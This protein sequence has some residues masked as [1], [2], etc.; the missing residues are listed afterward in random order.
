MTT[1]PIFEVVGDGRVRL[2]PRE[3]KAFL[4]PAGD[5]AGDRCI[6][7]ASADSNHRYAQHLAPHELKTVRPLDLPNGFY[8]AIERLEKSNPVFRNIHFLT[9]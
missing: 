5:V 6:I 3:L 8:L 9:A 4:T 2:G 7:E 1:T